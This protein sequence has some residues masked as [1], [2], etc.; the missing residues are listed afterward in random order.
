MCFCG[1]VVLLSDAQLVAI[2]DLVFSGY[3]AGSAGKFAAV[4]GGGSIVAES[5]QFQGVGGDG[6]EDTVHMFMTDAEMCEGEEVPGGAH[7]E[8][9]DCSWECHDEFRMTSGGSG[10]VSCG[11]G[12]VR[13]RS[14]IF[15][16]TRSAIFPGTRR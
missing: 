5:R 6:T 11:G 2:G 16:G 7:Y 8:Y 15:P 10:C 12:R 3:S 14:A 9:V 13:L 4:Y 1:C